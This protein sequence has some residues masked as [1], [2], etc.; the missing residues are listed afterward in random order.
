VGGGRPAGV[1]LWHRGQPSL[2]CATSPGI[3]VLSCFPCPAR[4]PCTACL[5]VLPFSPPSATPVPQPQQPLPPQP[6]AEN[7]AGYIYYERRPDN[8]SSEARARSLAQWEAAGQQASDS[9]TA[10]SPPSPAPRALAQRFCPA[11]LAPPEP[12]VQHACPCSL[13]HPPPPLPFRNHNN[14]CPRN[15]QRRT[16][17]ITSTTSAAR[18]NSSEARAR[19]TAAKVKLQS[20][21]RFALETMSDLNI[22]C[23]CGSACT[24]CDINLTAST[25][26]F[27]V[28]SVFA[29]MMMCKPTLMA[30]LF[31]PSRVRTEISN[32]TIC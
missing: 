15:Y 20:H 7:P 10:A 31:M 9:G 18:T 30:S 5:S 8:L 21:C 26:M 16:P 27:L 2:P 29:A 32:Q 24:C 14:H 12:H 1:G 13:F 3:A 17:Q 4:A 23:V 28:R 6:S 11:F 19:A 25:W 22:W